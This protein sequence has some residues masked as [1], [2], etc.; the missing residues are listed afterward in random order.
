MSRELYLG[1]GVQKVED[2]KTF[3]TLSK[4]VYSVSL[5]ASRVTAIPVVLK[6][7]P[8]SKEV[9]VIE[10]DKITNPQDTTCRVEQPVK[11]T[12]NLVEM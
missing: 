8:L 7:N 4:N 1:Y 2:S 9:F 12:Y 5:Q 3:H 10:D 6:P 11:P